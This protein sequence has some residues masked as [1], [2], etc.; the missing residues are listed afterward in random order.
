MSRIRRHG[1]GGFRRNNKPPVIVWFLLLTPAG[2]WDFNPENS[3]QPAPSRAGAR[4]GSLRLGQG[5]T[6]Q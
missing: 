2:G 5:E 4:L 3:F 1:S 6:N